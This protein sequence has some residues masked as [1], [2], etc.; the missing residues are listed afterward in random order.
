VRAFM[1]FCQDI[2]FFAKTTIKKKFSLSAE[3]ME[4]SVLGENK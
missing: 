2:F 3:T 1:M 4:I